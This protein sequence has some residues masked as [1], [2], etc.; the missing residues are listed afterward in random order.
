MVPVL[1]HFDDAAQLAFEVDQLADGR[2]VIYV[3]G[4][5]EPR[6]GSVIVMDANRVEPVPLTYFQVVTALGA[7]GRG[8]SPALRPPQA[9]D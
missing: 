2:R 1:I 4:S 6:T 8:M 9:S 7:L 5:P 3:P